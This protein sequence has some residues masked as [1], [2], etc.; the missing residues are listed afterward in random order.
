L[1][2]TVEALR[3]QPSPV[4]DSLRADPKAVMTL[5]GL[6]PD[7]WQQELLADGGPR[8]LLL[9]SRQVGK[10][11]T[12]G[13]LAVRLILT[14]PG[15]LVL[16]TAPS[17]RQS[18]E[19]FRKATALYRRLGRPVPRLAETKTSIELT[20]C[21]RLVSLPGDP[22]TVRSFSAAA[23][24]VVDE[25]AYV[26]DDL[27]FAVSPMLATSGGRLILCG[28][29]AGQRGVFHEKWTGSEPWQRIRVPATSCP[30]LDPVFLAQERRSMGT[31]WFA[32]EYETDFAAAL[33]SVFEPRF[34]DQACTDRQP[35]F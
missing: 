11:T 31:R 24:V 13:A 27:V 26:L 28:T 9:A 32:Q 29:P 23:L 1:R 16:L 18:T 7:P 2:A 3:P 22:S 25:A 19:V 17:Q 20:N 12:A 35:L 30:R 8:S 5:A 33:D 14:Q 4:L 10:S 6:Q 21:S 34:I 15:A